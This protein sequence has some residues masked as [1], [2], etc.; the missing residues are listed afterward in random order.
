[1]FLGLSWKEETYFNLHPK[2]NTDRVEMSLFPAMGKQ[3]RALSNG[4]IARQRY[5]TTKTKNLLI[6]CCYLN[7][8]YCC[9]SDMHPTGR[10][11]ASQIPNRRQLSSELPAV[12][13]VPVRTNQRQKLL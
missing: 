7:C 10:S 11:V 3:I 1:M 9:S 5:K 12:V 6:C 4:G 13:A 8:G 2:R